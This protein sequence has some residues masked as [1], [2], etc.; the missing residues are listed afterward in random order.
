MYPVDKVVLAGTNTTF[1]CILGEGQ[2]LQEILYMKSV[3]KEVR[4][5]RRTYAVTQTLQPPSNISGTNVFCVDETNVAVDGAVIFVGCKHVLPF[6]GGIAI[7]HFSYLGF[8]RPNMDWSC[9][10]CI[11]WCLPVNDIHLSCSPLF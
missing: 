4:L 5:S 1:C 11:S 7:S 3:M 8:Q 9:F 2:V 6:G 10:V